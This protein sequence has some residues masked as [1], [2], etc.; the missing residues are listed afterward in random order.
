MT[1]EQEEVWARIQGCLMTEE[2]LKLLKD[3][4]VDLDPNLLKF[5]IAT[6]QLPQEK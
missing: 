2:D 3:L 1:R 5:V 6:Q 4:K